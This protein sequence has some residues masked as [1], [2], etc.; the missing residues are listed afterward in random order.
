MGGAY[1]AK[2]CH[3]PD[4]FLKLLDVYTAHLPIHFP[5]QTMSLL[6]SFMYTQFYVNTKFRK[7]SKT[8]L[9]A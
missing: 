2:M 7:K 9:I 3:L 4:F 8:G 1:T 6:S 5:P